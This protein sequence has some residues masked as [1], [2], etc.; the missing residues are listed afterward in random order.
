MLMP[1]IV[2]RTSTGSP[3]ARAAFRRG[4]GGGVAAAWLLLT[5]CGSSPSTPQDA[6]TKFVQAVNTRNVTAMMAQADAPFHFRQQQW[7]G[8][9]GGPGS[10]RKPATERVAPTRYELGRLLQDVAGVKIATTSPETTA[11]SSSDLLR[12]V[13]GDT[14]EV[15][16][17]LNLFVF[18]R[19]AKDPH[20]AIVGVDGSNKIRAVYVS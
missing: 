12:D 4:L 5:A 19:D 9:P 10:V 6:A 14:P 17:G 13:L 11:A 18:R 20:V 15:W 1:Q 8:E 2:S 7:T 16:S 3:T